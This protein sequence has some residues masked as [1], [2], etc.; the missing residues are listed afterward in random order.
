MNVEAVIN[1]IS[2]RLVEL[3][4]ERKYNQ[5][6][7]ARALTVTPGAVNQWLTGRSPLPIHRIPE[8]AKALGCEIL[9]LAPDA[10]LSMTLKEEEEK[11]VMRYRAASP[12][13]RA[14]IEGVSE[15]AASYETN[16]I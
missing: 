15:L 6:D 4:R 16:K 2:S 10:P 8:I 9:E 12:E 5:K 11:I 1:R 14:A 13:G 7:L 3:K